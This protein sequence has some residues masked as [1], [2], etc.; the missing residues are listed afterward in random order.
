MLPIKEVD[1]LYQHLTEPNIVILD[2]SIDFQ[3]PAEKEKDKEHTIPGAIRF[4]YDKDICDQTSALPHMFPKQSYF[5]E[6]V[7]A[8][9]INNDDT[10]IVYDNSGTYASPRAWWMFKTMGCDNVY[11]LNGGLSAW[12]CSGYPLDTVY[13][14]KENLGNFSGV[15]IPNSFVNADYVEE[16]ITLSNSTTVDA[17]ALDRFLGKLPEPREGVRRGHI[18]AAVCLPFAD[19]IDDGKLKQMD[20]LE[21]IFNQV[22]PDKTS[23]V[24][25]SCGSGVTA[26]ILALAASCVGYEDIKVYDGSW[27]EWGKDTSRP[28]E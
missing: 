15:M 20:Q 6:R 13:Q 24:I 21:S 27:T 7:Q 28:I 2:C 26:C 14:S 1:W 10:I 9:G 5:N 16:K 8:L 11:V 17:R 3:I 23:E 19:V 4:D 18:P 12:K 25:F 22:I